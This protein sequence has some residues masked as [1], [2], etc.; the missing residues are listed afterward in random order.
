MWFIV[1]IKGES[2]LPVSFTPFPDSVLKDLLFRP[3]AQPRHCALVWPLV[4]PFVWPLRYYQRFHWVPDFQGAFSSPGTWDHGV[5]CCACLCHVVDDLCKCLWEA[6]G[7]IR[8]ME[9][10]FESLWCDRMS[11]EPLVMGWQRDSAPFLQ[12]YCVWQYMYLSYG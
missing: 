5:I 7:R 4:W 11:T 3:K 8:A 12:T 2:V 10:L 1:R 6:H 9:L